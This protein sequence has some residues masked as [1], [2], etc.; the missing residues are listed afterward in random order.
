MTSEGF[1]EMFE[2][3]SA[4]N[5]FIVNQVASLKEGDRGQAGREVLVWHRE[6]FKQKE[7]ISEDNLWGEKDSPDNVSNK[8]A[9][10]TNVVKVGNN[11][12]NKPTKE[13]DKDVNEANSDTDNVVV[14][15]INFFK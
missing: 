2:G 6:G 15:M 1:G 3:D 7:E 12:S 10:E 13:S 9:F 5:S 11:H 8:A 14:E 4:V